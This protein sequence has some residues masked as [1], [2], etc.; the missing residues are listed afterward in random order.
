MGKVCAG[1]LMVMIP[2]FQAGDPGSIPGRR[3]FFRI[4]EFSSEHPWDRSHYEQCESD[5]CQVIVV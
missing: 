3:I 1:S 5:R 2:A 4:S